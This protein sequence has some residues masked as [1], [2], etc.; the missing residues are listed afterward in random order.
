MRRDDQVFLWVAIALLAALFVF[1]P[2][3]GQE[4]PLPD[5]D[6]RKHYRAFRVTPVDDSVSVRVEYHLLVG[7]ARTASML[8]GGR[9]GDPAPSQRMVIVGLTELDPAK[10]RLC[11]VVDHEHG[12]PPALREKIMGQRVCFQHD[13]E[14]DTMAPINDPS[15]L[16]MEDCGVDH[17][18]KRPS[19][20]GT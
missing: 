19:G 14:A 8:L 20:V 13:P 10:S 9:E 18:A 1:S 3:F 4:A 11:F 7:P 6:V 12:L 5:I 17:T 15:G 2:A 16:V